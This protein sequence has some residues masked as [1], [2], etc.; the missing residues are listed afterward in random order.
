MEHIYLDTNVTNLFY[1]PSIKYLHLKLKADVTYSLRTVEE[2]FITINNLKKDEKIYVLIDMTDISFEYIPKEVM[3]YMANSPYKKNHLRIALIA[4]GLSQKIF[5]NF[6][7]NIFKPETNTKIFN[8]ITD[9]FKWFDFV[10]QEATLKE[11]DIA[12][13][14]NR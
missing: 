3:N 11:I 13:Q 6:Y 5:G 2:D 14:H 7:L 1:F 9:A 12:L 4:N 8:C 10:D